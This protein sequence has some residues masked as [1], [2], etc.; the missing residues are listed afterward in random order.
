MK[1]CF[2]HSKIQQGRLTLLQARPVSYSRQMCSGWKDRNSSIQE[3]C[4]KN[5]GSTGSISW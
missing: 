5:V 1:I 4:V 3:S 2:R